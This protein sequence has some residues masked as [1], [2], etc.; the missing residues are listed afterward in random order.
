MTKL[1]EIE[2][3][4][5]I[6]VAIEV[7]KN[8]F[9]FKSGHSIGACV[10]TR[11]GEYFGG[12]NTEGVISSMGVCAEMS[13]IDHAVIHGS[14]QFKAIAVIDQSKFVYPCGACRQYMAQFYQV[15]SEDI[16][17]IVAKESGE[18][19]KST[20]LKLLPEAFLTTTFKEKIR[21]F[22]K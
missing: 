2:I 21:A 13:A 6:G 17:V 8:A 11:K 18:Y 9:S 20:L 12:C 22:K 1:S 3:K 5:M 7:R 10:L 16:W 15:D 14:Y 19:K 4:K